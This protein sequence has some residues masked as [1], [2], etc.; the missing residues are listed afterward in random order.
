MQIGRRSD[1]RAEGSIRRCKSEGWP[2]SSAGE[3]ISVESWKLDS[4]VEP[5]GQLP[6]TVGKGLEGRAQERTVR[7]ESSH[8]S[9]A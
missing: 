7:C 8:R 9:E 4:R 2:E 3:L 1:G 5:E 6:V